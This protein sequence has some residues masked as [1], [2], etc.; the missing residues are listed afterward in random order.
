M[1]PERSTK[2]PGPISAEEVRLALINN[3]DVKRDAKQIMANAIRRGWAWFT[4]PAKAEPDRIEPV[5]FADPE[6]PEGSP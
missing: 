4:K 1:I 3:E 5:S 2:K 6:N